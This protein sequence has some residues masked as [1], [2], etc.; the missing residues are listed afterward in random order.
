M[1]NLSLCLFVLALSA[2]GCENKP[3]PKT[4]PVMTNP[5][6]MSGHAGMAAPGGAVT[7]PAEK[8]EGE[9]AAPAA[10]EEKKEG[11]AATP[12]AAP[13]EKKEGEAAAPTESEKKE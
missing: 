1:K 4:G 9:A 8:K 7:A 2:I 6:S 13:E 3:T 10:A 11:E 12:A 5:G